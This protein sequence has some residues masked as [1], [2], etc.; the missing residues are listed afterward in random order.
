MPAKNREQLEAM[1]PAMIAIW[2]VLIV[3]FLIVYWRIYVKAGQPG[4]AS[5]VPFYNT[6][7]LI[8]KILEM[9]SYWFWL[10]LVPC[11]NLFVAICFIFIQPFKLAEKFGKGAGFGVGL[12]LL[13]V[14]FYPILAFGDARYRGGRKRRRRDDYYYD[15]EEDDEEE[16]ERP[17]QKRRTRRGD[18]DD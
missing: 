3:F 15:D 13:G 10:L 9:P 2:A 11:I 5:L 18:D 1:L 6:Y 16:E 7:V 12:L 4:W 14:V 17:W 8:V